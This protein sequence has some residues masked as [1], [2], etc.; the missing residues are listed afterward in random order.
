MRHTCWNLI[1]TLQRIGKFRKKERLSLSFGKSINIVFVHF[2]LQLLPRSYEIHAFNIESHD[3]Q[4]SLCDFWFPH[5]CL[6]WS[7]TTVFVMRFSAGIL[8]RAIVG[9]V[10]ALVKVSQRLLPCLLSLLLW[11]RFSV[12]LALWVACCD[13]FNSF[14][15]RT[16]YSIH[17]YTSTSDLCKQSSKV[18]EV[19]ALITGEVMIGLANAKGR[20]M[21]YETSSMGRIQYQ[22]ETSLCGMIVPVRKTALEIQYN[23]HQKKQWTPCAWISKIKSQLKNE[24]ASCAMTSMAFALQTFWASQRRSKSLISLA[25]KQ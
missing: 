23:Y 13:K 17:Q 10:G 2:V 25:L 20:D 19:N 1:A 6:I 18:I 7:T 3:V 24:A 12:L 15:L 14:R 5:L 16:V 21:W 4:C 8:S 11:R 22:N 9:F